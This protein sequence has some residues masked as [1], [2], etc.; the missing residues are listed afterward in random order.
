M[1]VRTCGTQRR[2]NDEFFRFSRLKAEGGVVNYRQKPPGGGN[3]MGAIIVGLRPSDDERLRRLAA[4]KGIRPQDL[5][6]IYLE[7]A[8]R[9]AG[10][11]T[12]EESADPDRSTDRAAVTA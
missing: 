6:G 8:I 7:R 9:R 5:A 2:T 1:P 11:P 12:N 3:N 4:S 10:A